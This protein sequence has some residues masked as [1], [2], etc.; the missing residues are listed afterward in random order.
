M[1]SWNLTFEKESMANTVA[2]ARYIGTHQSGLS[3]NYNTNTA[4]PTY[5]WYMT[6]GLPLPTGEYAYVARRPYDQ[7]VYGEVQEYRQSG[8]ANYNGI[9]LELTR[10]YK[11]GYAFELSY[12]MSNARHSTGDAYGGF[13]PKPISTCPAITHGLRLAEPAPEL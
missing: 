1:Q 9:E 5:I 7:Q 13:M 2:R 3:Q 4:T 6:T 12:L 10:R 8:W 11:R